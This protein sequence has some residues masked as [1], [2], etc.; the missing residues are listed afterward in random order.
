MHAFRRHLRVMAYFASLVVAGAAVWLP[1]S[2]LAQT[3]PGSPFQGGGGGG[4]TFTGGAVA[5]PITFPDGTAAIPSIAWTADA[6]GTGTGFYRRAANVISATI[7]GTG[8]MEI[9]NGTT[10]LTSGGSYSWNSSTIGTAVD[11]ELGRSGAPGSFRIYAGTTPTQSGTTCGTGP[12]I[13]GNNTN[14]AVTLGTT[15]GLPC[16]I[17]FNGTWTNAPRCYL[18]PEVLTTAS[19][20]VR[21]TTITTTGFIITSTA[22]LVA[23]D[24]VSWFCV[25]S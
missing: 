8:R 11:L 21:A 3:L 22:A 19:T 1:T 5:N 6:D 12:T 13:A 15:P 17:V 7:G 14:G 20:T 10:A 25:S 2:V 18:N 24:K 16:T 4:G 23:T 9:Q